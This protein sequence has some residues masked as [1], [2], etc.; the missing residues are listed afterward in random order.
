MIGV[1][2]VSH[3]AALADAALA[4]AGQMAGAGSVP[5]RAAAGA[6]TDPEGNAV[7]GTDATAVAAGIDALA[8]AGADG[9]V[10]LTDL[11]SAVM[12]AEMGVE[13][14]ASDVPVRLLAAPFVEGLVAAV[15]TAGAGGSLDDVAREATNAL[16][17]KGGLT[18]ADD[19]APTSAVA[20][21]ATP[22]ENAAV[23]ASG[24][25][26]SVTVTDPNGLH[27]R[28]VAQFVRAA[29]GLP[30]TVTLDRTG[31]SVSAASLVQLLTL[32][33]TQG[34]TVTLTLPAG[35]TPDELD[36]V[37]RGFEA[38]QEAAT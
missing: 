12:S 9:I 5:V 22:T 15:T 32:G 8:D 18:A 7:L 20:P 27:A 38:A 16:A 33:A 28:P 29:A 35:H 13:F 23:S 24:L 11:G 34:D 10:I 19:A 30:V 6:G 26:A 36:A 21:P 1:L 25:S 17:A 4:L 14:R 31:Q 37:V 2:A 3:S